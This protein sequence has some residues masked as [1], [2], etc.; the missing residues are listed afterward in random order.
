MTFEHCVGA[1]PAV[2]ACRYSGL[3][4]YFHFGPFQAVHYHKSI[5]FQ[6]Q[7]FKCSSQMSYV[8]NHHGTFFPSY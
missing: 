3:D 5:P 2:Y 7:I 4:K 8:L 6:M 1:L